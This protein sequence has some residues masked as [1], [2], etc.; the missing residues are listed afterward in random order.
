[1]ALLLPPLLVRFDWLQIKLADQVRAFKLRGQGVELEPIDLLDINEETGNISVHYAV[2]YEKYQVLKVW[3][4]FLPNA[5]GLFLLLFAFHSHH[6]YMYS[7]QLTF[8]ARFKDTQQVDT[9]L[10]VEV[11]IKD[12]NDNPPVFDRQWVQFS[13]LESTKQGKEIVP[14]FSSTPFSLRMQLLRRLSWNTHVSY[15]CTDRDHPD[16]TWGGRQGRGHQQQQ[17]VWRENAFSHTKNARHGVLL[18]TEC[19]LC[20]DFI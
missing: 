16:R 7:F 17:Q 10:G 14:L 19:Q 11:R 2:D 6:I 18:G 1:M 9:R 20:N 13:I 5:R 15:L 12:A 3:G 4:K 8:E